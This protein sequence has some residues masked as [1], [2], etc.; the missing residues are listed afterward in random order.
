MLLRYMRMQRL[1][2]DT[3]VKENTQLCNPV[4]RL[5]TSV[6][7]EPT[8]DKVMYELCL[9]R[10]LYIK[11]AL[12]NDDQQHLFLPLCDYNAQSHCTIITYDYC[13]LNGLAPLPS[14]Y[15]HLIRSSVTEN[16]SML[17]KRI[18]PNCAWP[19]FVLACLSAMRSGTV[20]CFLFTYSTSYIKH[21]LHK[22]CFN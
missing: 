17:T 13:P 18:Y 10:K 6:H 7:R 4:Q 11:Q 2:R 8:Y 12:V 14:L 19:F 1:D 3:P 20:K 9:V 21:V 16:K 22:L 15:R 5:K